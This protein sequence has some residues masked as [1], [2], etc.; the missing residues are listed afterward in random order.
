MNTPPEL[1]PDLFDVAALPTRERA[2]LYKNLETRV[3][4]TTKAQFI[5]RYLKYFVFVTHHGT[6]L[7]AFAGPQNLKKLLKR[8]G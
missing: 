3:W 8:K 6:Y 1:Q 2:K 5:A 4:T 7:D